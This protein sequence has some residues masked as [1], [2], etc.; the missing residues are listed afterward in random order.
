MYI[1][2]FGSNNALYSARLPFIMFIFLLTPFNTRNCCSLNQI[3]GWCCLLKCFFTKKCTLMLFCSQW[4]MKNFPSWVYFCFY[5]AFHWHY[6]VFLTQI[7]SRLQKNADAKVVLSIS[8]RQKWNLRRHLG[9][10]TIWFKK[11]IQKCILAHALILIMM[12]KIW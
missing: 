4:N 10:C 1:Y 3:S 8:C 12:S 2:G 9:S 6:T 5:S 7:I 11:C